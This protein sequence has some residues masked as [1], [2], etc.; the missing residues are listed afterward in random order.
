MGESAV[1]KPE[2]RLTIR[3]DRLV[4]AVLDP[5]ITT[6]RQ[7][8][9]VAGYSERSKD[10]IVSI[11]L[12]KEKLQREISLRKRSR[13][14]KARA[15]LSHS[16]EKTL[17]EVSRSTDPEFILKA[18]AAATMII[19]KL[20]DTGSEVITTTDIMNTRRAMLVLVLNGMQIGTTW[21]RERVE[22]I[23]QRFRSRIDELSPLADEGTYNSKQKP[24]P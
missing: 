23:A 5:T 11:S 4:D 18:G 17:D 21:P 16:L 7:A 15:I 22:A 24:R 1:K 10:S 19:E 2:R 6:Q 8:G 9:A 20:G 12:K 14:D 3:Q 13:S